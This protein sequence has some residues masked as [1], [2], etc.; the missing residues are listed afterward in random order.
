[1]ENMAYMLD[2]SYRGP[3]SEKRH[4]SHLSH[5]A[6]SLHHRRTRQPVP[7]HCGARRG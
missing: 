1:M 5:L 7:Y 3:N 6:E 4:H 2:N